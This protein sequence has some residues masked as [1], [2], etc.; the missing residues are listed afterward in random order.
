MNHL[1][2]CYNK[3]TGTIEKLCSI[4]VPLKLNISNNTSEFNWSSRLVAIRDQPTSN[5]ICH[6]GIISYDV[7]LRG[8]AKAGHFTT[9]GKVHNMENCI[10]KCCQIENCTV[11]MML[12]D[13][14]FTVVCKNEMLCEKKPTPTS[15]NFNPK[16]AYV[17]RD[18]NKSSD[19]TG[20]SSYICLLYS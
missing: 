16:I 3:K 13:R 14:C 11:A 9:H 6:A 20:I 4:W 7:S 17:F 15:S 12:K 19:V 18:K 1:L 10:S 5:G 2:I 8:G